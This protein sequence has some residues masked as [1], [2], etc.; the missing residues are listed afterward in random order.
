MRHHLGSMT[1]CESRVTTRLRYVRKLTETSGSPTK[2]ATVQ[3]LIW[4]RES[5]TNVSIDLNAL[6]G[7]FITKDSE[8]GVD[9]PN[10]IEGL[11]DVSRI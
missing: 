1:V 9:S 5:V 2:V 10:L 8:S 4:Q 6:N 3:V 11:S 7:V